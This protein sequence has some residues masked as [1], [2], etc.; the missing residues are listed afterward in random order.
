MWLL[1]TLGFALAQ[2]VAVQAE[3]VYPVVANPLKM[4]SSGG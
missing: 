1:L 2:T 3:M 4:A